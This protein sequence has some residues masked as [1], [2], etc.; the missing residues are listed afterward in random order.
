MNTYKY[1]T[2][3]V[4]NIDLLSLL[5]GNSIFSVTDSIGRIEYANDNFCNIL[6]CDA[7]ELIGETHKLLKSHLYIGD[8]YMELWKTIKK[9]HKWSGTLSDKSRTGKTFWLDTTIIPIKNNG[10]VK[11]ISIYNDVTQQRAKNIELSELKNST[12][13][14]MLNIPGFVFSISRYGKIKNA[15]KPF[16]NVEVDGLIGTYIYD[17]FNPS[18]FEIFKNNV[19]IVFVDKI[20]NQFETSG[21]DA[22]G[23]KVFYSSFISPVFDG[24]GVVDSAAICIHETTEYKGISKE[25]LDSQAKYRSIYQ[26]IN[27][28]IIVVADDKGNI[29]EWNKGA[30][31]AFGYTEIE[32]LGRR[33]T[34]LT[35]KKLRESNVKV[36]LEAI[37]KIKNNE[38][39][40]TIEMLCLRKNGEEFPVEFALSGLTVDSENYYCAMMLDITKRNSLQNK[41][42]QKTK[43]LEIFLY[44]SAH[45]L[46]AP[47]SSAQRLINLLMEENINEKGKFLIEM[48]NTTINSGRILLDNLAEASV[49]PAKKHEYRKIDFHNCIDALLTAL[50]GTK[51]FEYIKFN[52]DIKVTNIFKSKPELI[53]SIFQNIIQNA[54]KYSNKPSKDHV[55]SIDIIVKEEYEEV[56]FLICDNGPGIDAKSIDKIFD[57]Y[58][59]SNVKDV[60]GNGIGL[61]IVKNIVEVLGGQI[62]VKSDRD[63]GVCFEIHLPNAN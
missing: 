46:K 52:L 16:H 25:S 29:V 57:L 48:L 20:S 53:T 38:V 41:L 49:I 33:L 27:V 51:N 56:I 44:R 60:P 4:L 15:N 45:D 26:S 1:Y 19:D 30:E 32:I 3:T 22:N 55:P 35:S 2:P 39:F 21:F 12:E 34:V 62:K 59:R 58:Y 18:C 54:I 17:Y 10:D 6:E 47:F 28:G 40:D 31:L 11:Y 5:E 63:F 50:S 13:K 37:G 9:G 24:I 7:H 14:F 23:R 61:Y 36:L 43:D 42:N 8:V